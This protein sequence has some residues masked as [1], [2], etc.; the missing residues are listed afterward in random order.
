[1][2]DSLDALRSFR[3]EAVGPSDALQLQERISFMDTLAHTPTRPRRRMPRLRARRGILLGIAIALVAAVGTASATGMIPDDVQ[4]A[5]GLAA[6]RGENAALTPRVDQAVERASAPTADGGTLELWTAPTKGGGTCAYLRQLDAAGAPA[7]SGPISCVVSLAGG[8]IM[9]SAMGAQP[10][11]HQAGTS[12]TIGGPLGDGHLSAQLEVDANGAGTLFG[13]VPGDVAKVEVVDAAGAVL[14]DAAAKDGWFLLTL[15]A[16]TASKAV[17]LV[18]QSA[19]G[20]TIDTVPVATPAPGT[21]G[22]AGSVG[23]AQ[24]SS[25]SGTAPG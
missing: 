1:M 25:G 16:G 7:D 15:P 3:P 6:A 5:L 20:A 18:A 22:T 14:A 11:S 9:G 8:G 2:N 23:S 13:Q 10:A 4:Q 17:S 12:M 21:P 19:S 24:F